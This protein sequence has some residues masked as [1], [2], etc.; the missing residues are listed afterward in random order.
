MTNAE[1]DK[2]LADVFSR[3]KKVLAAKA[4]DYS[5]EDDRL[6]NFKKAAALQTCIPEKACMG[7]MAKYLVAVADLVND[8]E[9]GTD[10][11][12]PAWEEKIGDARNYLILLEGL[13]R[14]RYPHATK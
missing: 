1:F 4:G 13:L 10:T 2:L 11:P 3:T 8:L 14:E 7:M 5:R 12:L 6:S 9:R